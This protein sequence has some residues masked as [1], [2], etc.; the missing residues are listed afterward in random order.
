MKRRLARFFSRLHPSY[1]KVANLLSFSLS[2]SLSYSR[3]T[4]ANEAPPFTLPTRDPDLNIL[5]ATLG[6]VLAYSSSLKGKKR[7]IFIGAQ[8]WCTFF[9][10]SLSLALA[11]CQT[12]PMYNF[13]FSLFLSFF[14]FFA[15]LF[16]YSR[17]RARETCVIKKL[18][19]WWIY[20]CLTWEY[21]DFLDC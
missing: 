20:T 8:S 6:L 7:H 2:L 4:S 13:F 17:V 16:F 10:L 3:Q 15:L 11:L 14:F 1:I 12:L 19:I 9:S 5:I 21:V 18:L